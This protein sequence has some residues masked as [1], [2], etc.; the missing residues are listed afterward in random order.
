MPV[1]EFP[2]AVHH[3]HRLNDEVKE[4][5]CYIDIVAFGKI[6][7]HSKNFLRKGAQVLVDGRLSQCRWESAEG[8]PRKQVR[9]GREYSS[10]LKQKQSELS[11][12]G[13]KCSGIVPDCVND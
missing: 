12:A 7:E 2:I 9:S 1:C 4:E 8:K 3:R 6:G 10:V 5:V 13:E 11:R